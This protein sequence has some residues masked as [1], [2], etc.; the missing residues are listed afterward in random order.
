MIYCANCDGEASM[1]VTINPTEHGGAERLLPLCAQCFE[2]FEWGEVY[3]REGAVVET[4]LIEEFTE[5][6]TEEVE[7]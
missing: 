2:A 7:A 4:E 3:G 1:M 5:D 6:E